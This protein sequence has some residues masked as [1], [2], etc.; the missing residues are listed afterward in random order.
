[1]LEGFCGCFI[2]LKNFVLSTFAKNDPVII[3]TWAG[4]LFGGGEGGS[5]SIRG[6]GLSKYQ[7][8]V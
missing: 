3:K 8:S 5:F 4:L 6:K 1:M 7:I 2:G